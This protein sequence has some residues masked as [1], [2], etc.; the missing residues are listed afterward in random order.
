MGFNEVVVT[1]TE[2]DYWGYPSTYYSYSY[3]PCNAVKA[4]LSLSYKYDD[5]VS[6][7]TKQL[8]EAMEKCGFTKDSDYYDDYHYM[9]SNI[10]VFVEVTDDDVFV[11]ATPIW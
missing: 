5:R 2:Y 6:F 7:I 1:N 8:P 4:R 9:N 11:T 3:S 10:K